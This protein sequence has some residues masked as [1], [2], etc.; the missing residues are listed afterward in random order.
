MSAGKVLVAAGILGS[1]ALI[2]ACIAQGADL[3]PDSVDVELDHVSHVSQHFGPDPTV[4]GYDVVGFAARW[5]YKR[6]SVTIVEGAIIERCYMAGPSNPECG[7]M[8]GRNRELFQA[9]VS[10]TLWSKP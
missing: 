2:V 1:A 8:V 4:Y 7:A 10:Y 9:R 5:N 6:A 3:R